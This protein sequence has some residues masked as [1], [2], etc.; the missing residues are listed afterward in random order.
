M[1]SIWFETRIIF[2]FVSLLKATNEPSATRRDIPIDMKLLRPVLYELTTVLLNMP[3][4]NGRVNSVAEALRKIKE[5]EDPD[6]ICGKIFKPMDFTYSC[7]DCG[8][9]AT[10]VMCAQ[11]FEESEHVNHNYRMFQ[12]SG[13]G[14]CDC[15]DNEAWTNAHACVKHAQV[16][17]WLALFESG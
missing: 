16:I 9:D 13:G 12:S 2:Q 8:V 10:C 4:G 14:T 7:R 11:C 6:Q 1:A 15:G 17:T 3:S 5:S